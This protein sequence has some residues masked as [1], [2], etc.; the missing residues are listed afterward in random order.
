MHTLVGRTGPLN[1]YIQVSVRPILIGVADVQSLIDQP[2]VADVQSGRL[3][4]GPVFSY[5]FK[6]C[7]LNTGRLMNTLW[8]VG[9]R[10]PPVANE[11]K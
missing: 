11:E 6:N 2:P 10:W 7:S 8:S 3:A 1:L 5:G 9:F 4:S